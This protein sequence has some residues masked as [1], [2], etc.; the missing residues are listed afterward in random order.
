MVSVLIMSAGSSR[1]MGKDKQLLL[2][3]DKP[4]LRRAVEAFLGIP[5]VGEILVITGK[6][7]EET[8]RKILAGLPVRVVPDGGETRQQSVFGGIQK[9]SE[10]AEFVAIHDGA[11][12]LV[13]KEEVQKVI[14][15][16]KRYGAAVLGVRVKDTIKEAE[17]GT[18]LATPDRSRLF[19]IQTPQVFRKTEYLA[20]MKLAM[21]KGLDF[22]DDAQLFEKIGR[23][24]HL[25]EG[26]Y[27][28]IK[29][30]TPE[31]LPAAEGFL[32]REKEGKPMLRIGK[33]YDVH[34][35][36]PDRQLILG[37]VEI[38]WK[39]GLLG[40][41]DADVLIHAIMDAMLGAL[42]LGDIGKLF[43]DND[44]AYAG[45]DSRML[46]RRVNDT[47]KENGFTV[48]NV[49][50]TVIAQ[51]PKL[52]P[53]IDSMREIIASDLEID[54]GQVSIKA[55]TEE[56]LGFTGS[57]EGIASDAVCLLCRIK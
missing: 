21:E 6:E 47:V 14:A 46:L 32:E 34:R 52:R 26:G 31:D 53:Y 43:P 4:V 49:D 55:T 38:P 41:S 22:T 39:L 17:N 19:Q 28:N 24:V 15:D 18:I 36:V 12:P 1:R 25:T 2:L 3:G 57:G 44:P 30:T 16:A 37:G 33:G 8:Y 51:A 35:L 9:V 23:P 40:H 56:G 10:K 29:I 50:A 42:A 45:A 11:R 20:A 54:P 48:S 13:K 7:T 27:Q 5:E